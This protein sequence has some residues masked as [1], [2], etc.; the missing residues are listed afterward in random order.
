MHTEEITITREVKTG[1]DKVLIITAQDL[2]DKGI[3]I[4]VCGINRAV[5]VANREKFLRANYV[6][7]EDDRGQLH[8]LKYRYPIK[9]HT[10]P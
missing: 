1:S 9:Y 2:R 10:M 8:C 4:T 7:F 6:F 5:W 3:D